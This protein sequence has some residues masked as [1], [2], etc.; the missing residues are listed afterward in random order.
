MWDETKMLVFDP[1]AGP[2]GELC[3]GITWG[4]RVQAIAF[5]Y[6]SMGIFEARVRRSILGEVEEEG[7]GKG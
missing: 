1:G 4:E 5:G 6:I 3:E 7:I 2:V